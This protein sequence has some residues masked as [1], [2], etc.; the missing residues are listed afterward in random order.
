[1]RR[2]WKLLVVGVSILVALGGC[3]SERP[4][5]VSTQTTG[6][7]AQ[8]STS[9]PPALE[10]LDCD[11]DD[12]LFNM[13]GDGSP[14]QAG[15]PTGA[16]PGRP[17]AREAVEIYRREIWPNSPRAAEPRAESPDSAEFTVRDEDGRRMAVMYAIRQ[18]GQWYPNGFRACERFNRRS[19]GRSS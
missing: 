10:G 8:S 12:L 9:V 1:M 2:P 18:G 6:S 5:S 17:T 11:P 3:T 15:Q 14:P 7:S 16:R 13:S 4:Q 19:Q